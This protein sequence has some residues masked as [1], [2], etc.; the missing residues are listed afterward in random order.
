MGDIKN[1]SEALQEHLQID[2]E[3]R[4]CATG[5][6]T[7]AGDNY[8]GIILK[9]NIE[10]HNKRTKSDRTLQAIVKLIP[11]NEFLRQIFNSNVTFKNEIEFYRTVIPL[12]QNFQ[13]DN[14]MDV[15]DYF[16]T[17]YGSKI[18]FDAD[19]NIKDDSVL[20]LENLKV[21]NFTVDDRLRGVDLATA[22][23][24]LKNLANLQA[25]V[26]AFKLKFPQV[27]Q[28]K[29]CPYLGG[30][31]M[32]TALP[33][34]VYQKQKKDCFKILSENDE[35]VHLKAKIDGKFE[36]PKVYPP[37]EPW[38]T[39]VHADLWVNNTMTRIVNNN[40]VEIKLIDF[41]TIQLASPADDLLM[42]IF[43]SLR[44]ELLEEN[45]EL[46]LK[47]YYDEFI[48]TLTS[49]KCA[50]GPFTYESYKREIHTAFKDWQFNHI[51]SMCYPVFKTGMK[52][53]QMKEFT[54]ETL[55]EEEELSDEHKNKIKTILPIF[56]KLGWI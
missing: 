45:L 1:I 20:I 30:A 3:I 13:R 29:V 47:Y 18:S 15:A 44:N 40:P 39:I 52:E 28:E 56:E 46:L 41:Q 26:V 21:K 49:L 9:A 34:V 8:G 22:K 42:Y 25:T 10:I 35:L 16:P 31:L 4:N 37:R 17:Y 14:G 32:Q 19:G 38:A 23:L 53:E 43:T 24:T 33:E 6:L 12:L 7:A 27:F 55:M 36:M 11:E 48:A 54:H 51:V 5:P 2:E 50:T